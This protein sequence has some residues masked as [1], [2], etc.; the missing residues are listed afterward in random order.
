MIECRTG[1]PRAG[2]SRS[3]VKSIEWDLLNTQFYVVTNIK[4]HVGKLRRRLD[5]K[6]FTGNLNARLCVLN[7]NNDFDLIQNVYRVR[8][9]GIY[10]GE[11]SYDEH[12]RQVQF[13][14][15][16]CCDNGGVHY[17]MDEWHEYMR[18]DDWKFVGKPWDHYLTQHA[19]PS[20]QFTWSSQKPK[21]V[22]IQF[23]DLTQQTLWYRNLGK[24]PWFWFFRGPK[25]I[26]WWTFFGCPTKFNAEDAMEPMK[27]E[28]IEEGTHDCPSIEECYD[29]AAGVGVQGFMADIGEKTGRI[30]VWWF[31]AIAVTAFWAFFEFGDRLFSKAVGTVEPKLPAIQQ[32]GTNATATSQSGS[33]QPGGTRNISHLQQ[34]EKLPDNQASPGQ[35]P[36][37]VTGTAVE[38][39]RIRVIFSNGSFI[40]GS[41]SRLEA[42]RPDYVQVSGVKYFWRDSFNTNVVTS[43]SIERPGRFYER[44][45]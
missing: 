15:K 11:A 27:W 26:A 21:K 35:E 17:Y 31:A 36:L 32:R 13:D 25:K 43:H 6:G 20:D 38:N 3:M 41:D 40:R 24:E 33:S 45:E 29:T 5:K 39:G 14:W 28:T 30:S 22:A 7:N 44:S 42:V 8:G 34:S 18:A 2:K 10:A 23:R 1:F 19:K 37:Y 16:T 12:R 9:P 4:L